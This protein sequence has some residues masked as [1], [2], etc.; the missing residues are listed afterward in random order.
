MSSYQLAT[1][2]I[3]FTGVLMEIVMNDKR[4]KKECN[5]HEPFSL[6]LTLHTLTCMGFSDC[7][8]LSRVS[9]HFATPIKVCFTFPLISYLILS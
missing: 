4:D 6:F 5:D 1:V 7:L 3:L 9:L 2:D 8:L